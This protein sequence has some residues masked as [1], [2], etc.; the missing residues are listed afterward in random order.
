MTFSCII[1]FLNTHLSYLNSL[2]CV[3]S[4]VESIWNNCE[5]FV[6]ISWK[7]ISFFSV[8]RKLLLTWRK[9]YVTQ[10]NITNDVGSNC[11]VISYY[12]NSSYTYPRVNYQEL[13][14]QQI[15]YLDQY[16]RSLDFNHFIRKVRKISLHEK[17]SLQLVTKL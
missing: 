7:Y 5:V 9:V 6:K 11:H 15:I 14:W 10:Q 2:L 13:E 16:N 8:C 4:H 12:L 1:H 17:N 3:A